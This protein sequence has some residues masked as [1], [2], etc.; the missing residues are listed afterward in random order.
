MTKEISKEDLHWLYYGD[1]T[2]EIISKLLNEKNK[3]RDFIKSL[4]TTKTNKLSESD[5][6]IQFLKIIESGSSNKDKLLLFIDPEQLKRLCELNIK[7]KLVKPKEIIEK[8]TLE[9]YSKKLVIIKKIIQNN[10]YNYNIIKNT[11]MKNVFI[12]QCKDQIG[13]QYLSITTKQI[14]DLVEEI[15]YEGE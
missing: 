13:K 9:E 5:L 7:Y 15:Y 2:E 4:L 8:E 14:F 1:E 12:G 10:K 6:I 11:S 3:F